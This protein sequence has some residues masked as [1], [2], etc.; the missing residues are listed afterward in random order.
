MA[1]LHDDRMTAVHASVSP[2]WES[3][4]RLCDREAWDELESQPGR[5]GGFTGGHFGPNFNRGV[6]A[7][8]YQWTD[9]QSFTQRISD[10]VFIASNFDSLRRR[11]VEMLFHPGTHDMVAYD[12][13]WGGAHHPQI[14]LYLGANTGHGKRGHPKLERDQSNKAAFLLQHFFPEQMSGVLLPPPRVEHSIVEDHVLE[15]LVRFPPGSDEE[16]GQIWWMYDRA[17]DGSPDYL[18]EM[19]PEENSVEMHYDRGRGLWVFEMEL[20]PEASHIDFFS[21]HRKTIRHGSVS[22]AT[23]ISSPYTR[24]ELPR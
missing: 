12:L 10:D 19:I 23:Y 20:D 17:P 5:R 18:N 9:L 22:Y 21:N 24:V 8:G 1:I 4:L 7:A 13:Q 2:I 11:G 6:L 16:S 14:P 15:V 3:P